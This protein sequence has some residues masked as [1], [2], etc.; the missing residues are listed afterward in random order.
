MKARTLQMTVALSLLLALTGT[1]RAA[2]T[3]GSYELDSTHSYVLFKVKHLQI[4]WSYGMFGHSE[5]SYTLDPGDLAKTSFEIRVKTD[6]VF[7]AVEKRDQHLKSPDFFNAKEFPWLTFRS[8]KVEKSAQ[9]WQIT[10]DLTLHGVTKPVTVPVT[11]TGAGQDPWGK[12][13]T[14][15]HAVFTIKRSEFGMTFMNP[16][17]VGDEVELTISVEGVRK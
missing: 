6:S 4:G 12:Y 10:G 13:R 15:L 7:T 1:A 5:G 11:L 8:T 3:A 2:E 16:D 9:G 17:V 14:A